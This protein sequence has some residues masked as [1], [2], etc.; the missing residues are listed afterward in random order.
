MDNSLKNLRNKI[1]IGYRSIARKVVT[2]QGMFFKQW[3]D[4]GSFK[5]GRKSSFRKR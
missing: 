4:D 5:R 3:L 1:E 2:R